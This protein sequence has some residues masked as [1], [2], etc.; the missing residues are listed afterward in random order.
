MERQHLDAAEHPHHTLPYIDV[1]LQFDPL[2]AD[3][4][5]QKSLVLDDSHNT[6]DDL[7]SDT[8]TYDSRSFSMMAAPNSLGHHKRK[9]SPDEEL[10]D[11]ESTDA[12]SD[13]SGRFDDADEES[14]VEQHQQQSTVAKTETETEGDAAVVA[15]GAEQVHSAKRGRSNGWPLQNEIA[16]D[17]NGMKIDLS[18]RRATPT[19]TPTPTKTKAKTK[20]TNSASPRARSAAPVLRIRRSRFIEGSMNDRVSEKPP[21]IFF[22]DDQIQDQNQGYNLSHSD[23]AAG[24]EKKTLEK[25][26]SGIFR[27]G[28]AI[29]SAFHPFGSRGANKPELWRNSQDAGGA[30]SQKEIM[31]QRQIKAEQAYAELKKSGY[32]G[33]GTTCSYAN[34]NFNYNSNNK[35]DAGI[36]DETWKAIQEKM[37]YKVANESRISQDDTLVAAPGAREEALTPLCAEKG[38]SKFK[39]FSELRKRTSNLSIPAIRFRDA[40]PM[41]IPPSDRE[42]EHNHNSHRNMERRQSRKELNRQAKLLK[43][44]SNLEDKL[45]RA[46][47]EL[48]EFVDLSDLADENHCQHLPTIPTICVDDEHSRP[49]ALPTIL[50]ERLLDDG[51]VHNPFETET[52][53]D[54]IKRGASHKSAMWPPVDSLSRKRR[55]PIAAVAADDSETEVNMMHHNVD[56]DMD[57]E[58]YDA[59]C[60]KAYDDNSPR[61]TTAAKRVRNKLR[62]TRDKRASSLTTKASQRLKAKQSSRNLRQ[63]ANQSAIKNNSDSKKDEKTTSNHL[64]EQEGNNASSTPTSSAQKKRGRTYYGDDDENIPPVPPVPQELLSGDNG[65]SKITTRGMK[66]VLKPRVPSK[67]F[68][69]PEDIF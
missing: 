62:S 19:P 54:T 55:Q 48:R 12:T 29:A 6:A 25:R 36:A 41:G 27:F 64:Q 7:L 24:G 49:S 23:A 68:S 69:W 28:K 65:S 60:G 61:S 26:S 58:V 2:Q 43:R 13:M 21:S 59:D 44:V 34:T 56:D 20:G 3:P 14:D 11:S 67:E 10:S 1:E 45:L 53:S 47:R 32:K 31:K 51:H 35:V 39:S 15:A 52:E 38:V 57:C 66:A 63:V 37:G 4:L 42:D 17:E 40:S 33:T 9:L 22:R 50:S 30:K 46:R 16:Y 5:L 18:A 8:D